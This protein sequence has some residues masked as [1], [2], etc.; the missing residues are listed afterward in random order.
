MEEKSN[1]YSREALFEFFDFVAEKGLLKRATAISRKKACQVILG[2]LSDTEA[3][4]L[5]KIDLEGVIA[6]HRNLAAGKII[7]KTLITYE[8]RTRTSLKDFFNYVKNPSSWKS[9]TKQ[10][11]R[12]PKKLKTT[13]DTD[14]LKKPE[15]IEKQVEIPSQ[16]SVYIDLQIHI[17]PEA[18]PEQ[19]DQIFDSMRRNLY[20]K[21]TGS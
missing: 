14:V 7:P 21:K 13:K 12:K 19:I 3:A 6:R 17:S 10:R 15:I 20:G 1:R 2:I 4:D 5:S 8:S 11:L 16:P 9:S 18:K